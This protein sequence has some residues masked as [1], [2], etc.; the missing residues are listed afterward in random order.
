MITSLIGTPACNAGAYLESHVNKTILAVLLLAL[1]ATPVMAQQKS[2]TTTY[3]GASAGYAI[4]DIAKD[5]GN[6]AYVSPA[7]KKDDSATGFKVYGGVLWGTW[8]LELGY[9]NLGSYKAESNIDADKF[10][11][12]AFAV[13]AVGSWPLND[14]WLLTGKVGL[15]PTKTK[16]TCEKNCG[17]ISNNEK[18]STAALF[19]LGLGWQIDRNLVLRADWDMLAG[20]K[21]NALN[22]DKSYSYN[23]FSL[24]LEVRF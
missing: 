24:G 22:A 16:Y 12:N 3:I 14:K 1:S 20:A 23:M 15:A 19:G 6:E 2:A 4:S 11:V 7:T 17:G 9:Y 13:S 8:G 21:T 5:F 10:A 18:T